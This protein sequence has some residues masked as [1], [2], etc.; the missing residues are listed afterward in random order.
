M[1]GSSDQWTEAR[2]VAGSIVMNGISVDPADSASGAKPDV[3]VLV[4]GQSEQC[5]LLDLD[6][7]PRVQD[8]FQAVGRVKPVEDN[9]TGLR[10]APT[11]ERTTAE[12]DVAPRILEQ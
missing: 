3:T 11:L 8:V 5:W 1:K 12:P 7:L 6:L 9:G 10:A 2:R 4:L